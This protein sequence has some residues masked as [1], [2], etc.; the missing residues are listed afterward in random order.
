M[1]LP[2]AAPVTAPFLTRRHVIASADQIRHDEEQDHASHKIVP[3]GCFTP[4]SV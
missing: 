3:F 4:I 1:P 2:R